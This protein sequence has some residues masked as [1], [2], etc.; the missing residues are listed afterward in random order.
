MMYVT[1]IV[2]MLMLLRDFDPFVVPICLLVGDKL[3]LSDFG[4][5]GI[6]SFTVCIY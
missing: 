2:A 1:I 3:L 6:I 5:Y 4:P